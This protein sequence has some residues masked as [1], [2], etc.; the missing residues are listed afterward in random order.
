MNRSRRILIVLLFLSFV[1]NAQQKDTLVKKLDSLNQQ[2]PGLKR[3]NRDSIRKE[4]YN[5]K[6]KINFPVYFTLL[7]SDLKQQVTAPFHAKPR[8][9]RRTAIVAGLTAGVLLA[10]KQIN[11][12]AVEQTG[13]SATLRGTSRFVT[14]FGGP[15][16]MYTLAALGTYGFLF[17]NEK[18][19]TTTFL[20]TQAYITSAVI[21][22]A[23][24]FLSGRQRPG[25]YDP[26]SSLNNPTWHGPFYQFKK[27][28]DGNKRSSNMYTSFPSGHT[29]LAFAAAT[30]YAMEYSDRPL[31]PILS[32]SAASLIGVSRV[33]ENKHWASDVFIGAIL[34][35][36][37]G[38]Q[39]VNNYHRYARL[40]MQNA[41]KKNTL[42]FRPSYLYGK[43]LPGCVLT[44]R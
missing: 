9:W 8:D 37:I 16:E 30:V 25:Y 18:I 32:Y 26:A 23:V 28:A 19:K 29:S 10:D 2:A 42:S 36:L 34:G 20:A 38:R 40:K 33:T 7:G 39:V 12:F 35:H 17:K 24:K 14:R 44:F 5:S 41:K 13:K 27:D 22:E 1:A 21:F 4:F 43:W 6:T 11:R 3:S 31:V 15:Y